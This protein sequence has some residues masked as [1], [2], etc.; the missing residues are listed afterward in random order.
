MEWFLVALTSLLAVLT[1]VGLIVDNVIADNIR[2][3]VK[4]VEQLSVR[5]DNAPSYQLIR[6]KVNRVRIAS[7][8]IEPIEHIRIDTLDIETD[9]IN[10]KLNDLKTGNLEQI[11]SSLRSPLQGAFHIVVKQD[12]INK[13]LAEPAIKARLQGLLSRLL[14][15]DIPKLEI[16]KTQVTFKDNNQTQV[17]VQ[18]QQQSDDPSEPP[19]KLEIVIEGEIKVIQG[20]SLELI[21]PSASLNGRRISQRILL[22]LIGSVSERLNLTQF[23]KQGIIA[24]LLKLEIE[25]EEISL[26]GFVRLNPLDNSVS[27]K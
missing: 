13:A 25:N 26:A 21:N 5:V 16:L 19:E 11:R 22:S 17:Q 1:P 27:Q 6:G 10:L 24:R 3:R 20:R 12:D 15:S 2:D 18:L 14:P 8:G 7:R 4:S 9:P 23:E